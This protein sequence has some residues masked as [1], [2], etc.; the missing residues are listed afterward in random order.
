MDPGSSIEVAKQV[1]T[2]FGSILG[3]GT[4]CGMLAQ[5]VKV[6]DVAV[7]LLVGMLLGPEVA[8]I[9][10]VRADSALNQLILIFG[11]CYILFD[12]GASLRLK[13][14]KEVWITIVV[15]STLGVAITAAITGYVAHLVLGVPL[16]VALLLGATL[17]STDPAT[18]VPIF[19]QVHVRDRVAQ[20]V[21]SES[22]FNDAMGAIATFTVLGIAMG[23]GEFSLGTAAFKLAKESILG[24]VAGGVLGY[25]ASTGERSEGGLRRAIVFGTILASYVV[26]DYGGQ[27]MRTL[28]LEDVERR[29]RQF[30]E[31][32]EF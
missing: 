3:V 11:S 27:R 2:V 5:K 8:G 16:I 22:A 12:G 14:L 18:L 23:S 9:V 24:I 10:N 31:L 15:I 29:Y 28:T 6:P 1:L 17:A 20:T 21:M 7:F 4:L 26:E 25:L 19:K 13:V 32:T 30:V